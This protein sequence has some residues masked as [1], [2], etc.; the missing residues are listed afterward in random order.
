M[1]PKTSG[2][3]RGHGWHRHVRLQIPTISYGSRASS[4]QELRRD[5]L[6]SAGSSADGALV[7]PKGTP[8]G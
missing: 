1:L 3:S 2:Q 8:A 6:P 7:S 4:G 5:N